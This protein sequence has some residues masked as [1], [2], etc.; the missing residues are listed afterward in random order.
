[1]FRLKRKSNAIVIGGIHY[2]ESSGIKRRKNKFTFFGLYLKNKTPLIKRTFF[3]ISILIGLFLL[4]SV[5]ISIVKS[6]DEFTTT[7]G[8]LFDEKIEVWAEPNSRAEGLF[9][10]HEGTKVQMLDALQ[11]WQKIRIANGSEGWLK[12]AILKKLN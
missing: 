1:M 3:V 10:L 8:I 5:S 7:H 6:S 4:S 11:E 12:N 9:I 2:W